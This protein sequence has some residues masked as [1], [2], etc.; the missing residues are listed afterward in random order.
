[1]SFRPADLLR[2][3]NQ[4]GKNLTYVSKGS[5]TYDPTTGGTTSTGTT[6]TVKGYFYN[7][8]VSDLTGSSIVT[9]DRRLVLPVVD[10]SSASLT[11][12]KK[13]DT[14]AGEQDTVSVVSVE[15]IMSGANPVCYICQVRE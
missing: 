11:A 15:R 12:P 8:S 13:G 6:Q 4:Y 14:F 2:L 10:T 5:S 7:Y 9:G 3:I 1:M